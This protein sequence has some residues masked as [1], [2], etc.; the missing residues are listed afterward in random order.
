MPLEIHPEQ[1]KE[2]P[3]S[4]GYIKELFAHPIRPN[5]AQ[6]L[7]RKISRYDQPENPS[8][9]KIIFAMVIRQSSDQYGQLCMVDLDV[10]E[11]QLPDVKFIINQYSKIISFKT[12]QLQGYM[13]LQDF[14]GKTIFQFENYQINNIDY[15]LYFDTILNSQPPVVKT[16]GL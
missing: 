10:P 4:Y 6:A 2:N 8:S 16:T 13:N 15:T 12:T 9:Q 5:Q 11:D 3:S 7:T 1:S 14:F